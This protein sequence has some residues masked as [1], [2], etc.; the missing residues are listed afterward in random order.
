MFPGHL[1]AI[2]VPPEQ[3][4]VV[5]WRWFDVVVLEAVAG[6]VRLWEPNHGEFLAKVRDTGRVCRPESRGYLSS[7]LA[8]A[9]WWVASAAVDHAPGAQ[10]ELEEV[11]RFLAEHGMWG[12]P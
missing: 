9:D 8:G 12:N 6:Q 11:Q 1:V 4:P 2:A 5:V 3:P 10:V 7:G